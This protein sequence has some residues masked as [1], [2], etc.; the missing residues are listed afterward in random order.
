MPGSWCVNCQLAP[1]SSEDLKASQPADASDKAAKKPELAIQ[2]YCAVSVVNRGQWV[3]GKP[4]LGVIHLGRLYLFADKQAMDLFLDD[5]VPF[6]PMLNEIDVVRFFE[7]RKIVP[8]K[9]EWGLKD[10]TYNRMFFFA[11]EAAMNHFWNEYERYTGAAIQVMEQA[12]RD[13]NPDT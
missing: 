10:P 7:E 3:E 2:G 12:I 9:R 13:A 5:P 1:P 4:E 11:D 6:T 8:G